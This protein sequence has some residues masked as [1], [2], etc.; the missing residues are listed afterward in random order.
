MNII[1]ALPLGRSAPVAQRPSC[2][3]PYALHGDQKNPLLH[4]EG[5][6]PGD[7]E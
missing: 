7:T 5:G 1:E 2:I 4:A 3:R 6:D